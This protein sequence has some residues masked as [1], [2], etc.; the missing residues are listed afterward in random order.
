M[1]YLQFKSRKFLTGVW[2]FYPWYGVSL[3]EGG[4]LANLK[5]WWR[6]APFGPSH[7]EF[8]FHAALGWGDRWLRCSF[9]SGK[10]TL[11]LWPW[12]ISARELL[13]YGKIILVRLGQ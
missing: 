9:R 11:E 7:P 13:G 3:N 12:G 1:P 8:G 5:C 4:Y 2:Y 10:F 6:S